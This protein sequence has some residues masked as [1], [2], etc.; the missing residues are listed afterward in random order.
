M[1]RKADTIVTCDICDHAQYKRSEL[2]EDGR[3]WRGGDEIR[4]VH[5]QGND[6]CPRCRHDVATA[7]RLGIAEDLQWESDKKASGGLT[8]PV[9]KHTVD[10]ADY[11]ADSKCLR[12][13]LAEEQKQGEAK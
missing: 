4:W 10:D 11:W 6:V 9:C 7:F 2:T 5:V 3:R 8:C 12:C 1:S 13:A